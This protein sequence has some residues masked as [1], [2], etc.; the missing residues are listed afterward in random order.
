M[1]NDPLQLYKLQ[2][3]LQELEATG[4][5]TEPLEQLL[6]RYFRPVHITNVASETALKPLNNDMVLSMKEEGVSG[7]IK[8][9]TEL[10]HVKAKSAPR[11]RLFLEP[12]VGTMGCTGP[13]G[14]RA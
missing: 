7:R 5:I 3:D 8:M 6:S 9:T 14:L 1:E 11:A 10:M 4:I 13:F 12:P 2:A